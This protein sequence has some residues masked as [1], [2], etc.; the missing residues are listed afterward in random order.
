MKLIFGQKDYKVILVF[1][2]WYLLG[3][4]TSQRGVHTIIRLR[5]LVT[6]PITKPPKDNPRPKSGI[7]QNQEIASS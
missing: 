3:Y 1:A 7:D 4:I 5:L 6:D 2:I